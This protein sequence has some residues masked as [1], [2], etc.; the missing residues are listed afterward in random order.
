MYNSA[1]MAN[2]IRSGA[3]NVN[4]QELFFKSII[5]GLLID[6]NNEILIR[7]KAVPHYIV[8]TG[9]DRMYLEARGYDF[10][11]EPGIQSNEKDTIYSITPRCV[12]NPGGISLDASQLTSPYSKGVIQLEIDDKEYA[13]LYTFSAEFRRMPVKISVDLTYHVD[14]Y[15]DL[16]EL[17][18]YIISSFGFI[19]SYD[20]SYLGQK[21]KC[22]YKIPEAFDGEHQM[23][24][25]G[26]FSDSR[27]HKLSLSIELETNMPIYDNKT[28][29]STDN[30]I[31]TPVANIYPLYTDALTKG[32]N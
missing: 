7:N 30:I 13:G 16:L 25:D 11:Q 20:I 18:Q 15:T 14:S 23:D 28:I 29:V 12:V 4:V 31:V 9:D 10:S 2:K 27:E 22:S 24:I 32:N 1:K 19:R 5:K 17:T 3:L 26:T 8:H 21:I 6:L